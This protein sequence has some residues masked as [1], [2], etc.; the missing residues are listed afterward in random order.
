VQYLIEQVNW[1]V[2]SWR[3]TVVS[4]PCT[5]S[6]SDVIC[7]KE[8]DLVVTQPGRTS[9]RLNMVISSV[10]IS[11]LL[12]RYVSKPEKQGVP[13]GSGGGAF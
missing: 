3:H 4:L 12:K 10:V 13:L 9:R 8:I 1:A 11:I 2:L 5:I 7:L 6:G